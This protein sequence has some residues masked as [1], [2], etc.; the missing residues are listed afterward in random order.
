M[1]IRKAISLD[2]QAVFDIRNVSIQVLCKGFYPDDLL[3]AWTDGD[4]PTEGFTNFVEQYIYV[5]EIDGAIVACGALDTTNNQ[6]DAI[7]VDPQHKNKGLGTAIVK[8]LEAIA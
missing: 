1:I 4:S 2:A 5:V 6:I 3:A 7:F 8:H